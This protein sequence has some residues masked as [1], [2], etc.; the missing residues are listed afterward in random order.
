MFGLKLLAKLFKALRS[1][2]SPGKI[3]GGFSWA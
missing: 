3:A 2:E 1:G